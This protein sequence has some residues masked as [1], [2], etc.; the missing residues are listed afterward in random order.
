MFGRYFGRFLLKR[1]AVTAENIAEIADLPYHEFTEALA[2]NGNLS[3]REVLNWLDEFKT[4][5]RLKDEDLSR[6]DSGSVDD[7]IPLFADISAVTHEGDS[8]I[9]FLRAYQADKNLSDKE[10]V[11]RL[12]ADSLE[13]ILP[14]YLLRD[15]AT[16]TLFI[17]KSLQVM[18]EY[19]FSN[20]TFD[21]LN[22]THILD[23]D[24]IACQE[25][26]GTHNYLFGIIG[27]PNAL[28]AVAEKYA[29]SKFTE[30]S[31]LAVDTLCE[32]VNTVTGI[33]VSEVNSMTINIELQPPLKFTNKVVCSNNY[34]YCL[35]V[36][37][38]CGAVS[39]IYCFDGNIRFLDS[40]KGGSVHA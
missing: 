30:L 13:T 7:I 31:P 24:F 14:A 18:S 26:K 19:Y 3:Q 39:L 33:F 34:I 12:N 35:P 4:V 20:P 40:E 11:E 2:K 17:R 32:I 29:G 16:Y 22:A 21:N 15:P 28:L 23:A 5:Y 38:E 1:S 36:E 9:R 8:L 6:F 37:I 25:M 10:V 27:E